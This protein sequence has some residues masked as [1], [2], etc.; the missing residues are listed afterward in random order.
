MRILFLSSE[1]AP[2]SKTGGLGDVSGALPWALSE[3][4]H[5]VRVMTPLYRGV[6]RATLQLVGSP[7]TLEFPFGRVDLRL[8]R[9]PAAGELLFVD[10]PG[11]FDR[12]EYYGYPDDARRFAAFSM[13][14]LAFTQA[15]GF[16]PDVVQGNDWPTGLAMLALRTGFAHTPLGRAR[17]VFTIHNLAYQG[18]F[19]ASEMEALGLPW[20]L[21]TPS[22][23]EFYQQLSFMKAGLVFADLL[24]TVSPTYAKEIQT[25]AFGV[26]LDG[27]LRHRAGAL[28]G[29]L[30]GV[31]VKEWNP[32]TDVFLPRQF[33]ST[34]LAGRALC[35]KELIASC[36]IDAP[37]PGMPLFG[38]IG[39]MAGQKG[40]DLLQVALP[41]LLEQGASAIVLGAGEPAVQD[42]WLSLAAKYPRRLCV[43]VGFDNSL[44]HRISAGSDFFVMPSRFEPC[45]LSQMYSL[46]Y[47]AIPV[48]HG[49]GGLR[50]TVFDLTQPN[51]NG[52]VFEQP[53][54]ESLFGALVRAVELF[55]DQAAYG[56]VQ[57]RGM[58][59]DFS[60][61]AAAAEYERLFA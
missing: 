3:R 37:V 60:W 41:K 19:P 9:A 10:A 54:P 28:H 17:R 59:A 53:T 47:G 16:V 4:G 5:H 34:E 52:I 33:T 27:L 44:A 11:L 18:L 31:D 22:G 8:F 32:A 20:D 42:A 12:D 35:R 25:P 38:V 43:R 29:I 55:R 15:D 13:A 40:A 7:L 21:F 46:L 58:A 56:V 39:R 30:N 6:P 14:A 51:G 48:V 1:V 26:G 24:T 23:V 61:A 57:R 49:V 2:F 36:R 45:G 50:D